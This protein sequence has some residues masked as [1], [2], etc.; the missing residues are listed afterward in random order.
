MTKKVN[1]TEI[2]AGADYQQRLDC[3]ADRSA[4]R[5]LVEAGVF[6]GAHGLRGLLQATEFWSNQPYTTR[7]YYGNGQFDYLHRDVLH[8]ALQ[9]LDG[10]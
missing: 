7:L 10:D 4:E 6:K 5:K 2:A 8:A 1:T 3:S 9:I